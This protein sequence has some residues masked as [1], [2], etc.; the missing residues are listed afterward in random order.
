MILSIF[1]ETILFFVILYFIFTLIYYLS[2]VNN[3]LHTTIEKLNNFSIS[4]P[5]ATV[6]VDENDFD[7]T[8]YMFNISSDTLESI[9]NCDNCTI[10]TDG[11]DDNVTI[12]T[13]GHIF[14]KS[15]L[16]SWLDSQENSGRDETSCPICRTVLTQSHPETTQAVVRE[17]DESIQSI[18]QNV[19]QSQLNV[20]RGNYDGIISIM[21]EIL[22]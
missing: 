4:V 2:S 9:R 8:S 18:I 1:L 13:C 20:R 17:D 12:T 15:C 11:L 7:G 5:N 16:N 10:C 22:D 21:A 3:R 14:H 19:L 6:Q